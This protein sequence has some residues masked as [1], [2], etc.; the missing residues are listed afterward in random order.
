MNRLLHPMPGLLW[1]EVREAALDCVRHGWPVL[2]GTYQLDDS[3]RWWG[4]RDA[5]G[6]LPAFP[7][8]RDSVITDVERTDEIWS[9]RPYSLLLA[10]GSGLDA[11]E[12]SREMSRGVAQ[13]LDAAGIAGPRVLT[14]SFTTFVLVRSIERTAADECGQ[15]TSWI[16]LPPST[17]GHRPYR[18]A[19]SPESVDWHV[20]HMTTVTNI[21]RAVPANAGA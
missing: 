18:W 8:W 4:R 5:A 6:L 7:D 1:S 20:P 17:N 14:P 3:G 13:R 11:V 10:C 16:P 2:P 21:L 15:P 12:V 19:S 9:R